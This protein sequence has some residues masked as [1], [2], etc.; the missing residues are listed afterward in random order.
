LW[1]LLFALIALLAAAL[2][3]GDAWENPVPIGDVFSLWLFSAGLWLF[4]V[5]GNFYILRNKT[6]VSEDDLSNLGPRL[7][8]TRCCC[9]CCD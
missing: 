5:I 4:I 8:I 7:L 3:I 2:I 9:C 1:N 6:D